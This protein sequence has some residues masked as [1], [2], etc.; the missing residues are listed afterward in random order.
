MSATSSTAR[1]CGRVGRR[2][3]EAG[4]VGRDRPLG[5]I[6]P[7]DAMRR[8]QIAGGGPLAELFER[9]RPVGLAVAD[10]EVP[11]VGMRA[12]S[13][14]AGSEESEA[15]G[16]DFRLPAPSSMLPAQVAEEGL[17]PP[18]RGL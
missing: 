14:G 11:L 17:E 3:L 9:E 6:G 7:A 5:L 16:S 8:H 4:H 2:E 1:D 12:G 15:G 13:R 10:F 18:T